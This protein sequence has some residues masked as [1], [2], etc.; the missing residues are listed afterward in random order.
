MGGCGARNR[1]VGEAGAEA[2]FVSASIAFAPPSRRDDR[3]T[4]RARSKIVPN[5]DPS[6]DRGRPQ[7]A[8]P[9]PPP[10]TPLRAAAPRRPRRRRRAPGAPCARRRRLADEHRRPR[11]GAPPRHGE[12]RRRVPRAA[13]T[14][15]GWRRCRAHECA[16]GSLRSRRPSSRRSA[17]AGAAAGRRGGAGP[18]ARRITWR[19]CTAPQLRLGRACAKAFSHSSFAPAVIIRR[20]RGG[21]LHKPWRASAFQ[22][23]ARRS[24]P[25]VAFESIS[26][27]SRGSS[28]RRRG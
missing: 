12:K 4:A 24:A 28:S 9:A 3:R 14:G 20:S 6:S 17:M 18:R 8:L 2:R 5:S 16:R 1:E 23:W 22:I 7:Q 10:P 15:R 11:S 13:R 26:T 25:T 21:W 19:T 27:S